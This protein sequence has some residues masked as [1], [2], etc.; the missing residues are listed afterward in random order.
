MAVKNNLIL[1]MTLKIRYNNGAPKM[2]TLL[3]V[4]CGPH[5]TQI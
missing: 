1:K 5:A 3:I 2:Q 4:H